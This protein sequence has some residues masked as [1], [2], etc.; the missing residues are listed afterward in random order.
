MYSCEPQNIKTKTNIISILLHRVYALTMGPSF[1][2]NYHTAKYAYAA[3]VITSRCFNS[4]NDCY[5][6]VCYISLLQVHF[7]EL[8]VAAYAMHFDFKMQISQ[9]LPFHAISFAYLSFY[10]N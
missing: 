6:L 3:I 5:V 9:F 10:Y 7:Y 8:S 2:S 1:H 4:S